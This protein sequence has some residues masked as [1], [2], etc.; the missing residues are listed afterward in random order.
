MIN[1]IE[2]IRDK[3][4]A[5]HQRL[6]DNHIESFLNYNSLTIKDIE[7]D[8]DYQLNIVHIPSTD[9]LDMKYK[10]EILKKLAI[11]HFNY[12]IKLN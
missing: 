6:L 9:P 10:I 8:G 4:L 12:E 5:E 3:L 7:P 2:Q 11:T 1:A